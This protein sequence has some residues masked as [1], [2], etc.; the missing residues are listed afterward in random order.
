MF[1]RRR[2]RDHARQIT[3]VDHRMVIKELLKTKAGHMI[4][5][6]PGTVEMLR[7]HREHQGEEKRLMG[8]AY[9][10]DGWIFCRTDDTPHHPE[11]FS[12]Q[13]RRKQDTYNKAN[14]DERLDHSSTHITRVIYTH[15]T[16]PMQSDAADRVAARFVRGEPR[17][18]SPGA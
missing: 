3:M 9:H 4:L 11:R 15:V 5:L 6:D 10:D 7:N 16:R 17:M 18:S 14:P 8:D 2:H 12:R 1:G 13:F